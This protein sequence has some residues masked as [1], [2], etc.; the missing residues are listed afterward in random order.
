M[1]TSDWWLMEAK[2]G[3]AKADNTGRTNDQRIIN[4]FV[5]I[6]NAKTSGFR[7]VAPVRKSID[8]LLTEPGGRPMARRP[9]PEIIG[10]ATESIR[11]PLELP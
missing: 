2:I 4:R 3:F 6:I 5:A 10:C 7:P 8:S 9:R 1:E 11:R